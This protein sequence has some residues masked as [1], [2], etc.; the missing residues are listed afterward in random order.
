MPSIARTA[1]R[2]GLCRRSCRDLPHDVIG[3]LAPD[4]GLLLCIVEQELVV[5]GTLEIVEAGHSSNP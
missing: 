1:L 3:G 2:G 5:D 4:N